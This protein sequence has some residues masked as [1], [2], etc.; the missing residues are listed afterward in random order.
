V[1]HQFALQAN[2]QVN[3]CRAAGGGKGCRLSIVLRG[4]PR[5]AEAVA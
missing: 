2:A 5:D 3:Q 1:L 4:E